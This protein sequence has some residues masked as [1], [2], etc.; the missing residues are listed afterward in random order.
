MK[1]IKNDKKWKNKANVAK[2]RNK[3]KWQNKPK[4]I[5]KSKIE[6]KI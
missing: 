3:K 1:K 2:T 6:K 4:K 5:K